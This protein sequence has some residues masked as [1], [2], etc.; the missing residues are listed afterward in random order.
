[1]APNKCDMGKW[2]VI[3]NSLDI[4]SIHSLIRGQSWKKCCRFIWIYTDLKGHKGFQN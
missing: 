1:M 3:S 4:D 2:K